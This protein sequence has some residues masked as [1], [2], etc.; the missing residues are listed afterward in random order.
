MTSVGIFTHDLYPFKPWGQGRYVFDLVRHLGPKWR[1]KL[2]VFSPSSNIA[3]PFHV[4]L[5][6]GSHDSL[7]KNI[8]FSLKLSRVMEDLI[9]RYQ[10]DLVHFQGGPG[11]LFLFNHPSVPVLYTVHHTYFQQQKYIRFQRWKYLLYL[12]E[13]FSYQNARY[14]MADSPSTREILLRHYSIA[15]DD[16]KVVPIGVDTTR[17]SPLD[18]TRIPN[19]LLFIGRLEQRKGID[20][21]IR[22]MAHV[23]LTIPDV[24]LYIAGGGRLDRSTVRYIK[25]QDLMSNVSFE[26]SIP[27]ESVNL[28]YNRVTAVVIPS[29]FEGFGLVAIESMASGTPVIATRVDGLKDIVIHGKNGL[30]AAYND[31]QTFSAHIVRVLTS[32]VTRQKLVE[33]GLQTVKY[34]YNWHKI[35][36]DVQN[37]YRS[38]G[39]GKC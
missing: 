30:L 22:T 36:D 27:D 15:P 11:G 18:Q 21:L 39:A 17:F 37:T 34:S 23:R 29:V 3:W 38:V 9:D 5:F 8:S 13:K 2:T 28:W 31:T 26:G 14:M 10:L 12:L 35:R 6:P 33:C 7:G 25:R 16:C 24:K 1:D 32:K 4:R 19:S 20:F